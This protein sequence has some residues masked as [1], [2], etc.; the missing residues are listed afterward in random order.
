MSSRVQDKGRRKPHPAR[1][2]GT[3]PGPGSSSKSTWKRVLADDNNTGTDDDDEFD[4]KK[5]C[6]ICAEKIKY[7]ALSPCNHTTC[8]KCTFRQRALYEKKA[9]LVCRSENDTLI[10]TEQ[11]GKEYDNFNTSNLHIKNDKYGIYFTSQNA[12][13]D[14]MNMLSFRCQICKETCSDL[15]QLTEHIRSHDK[16]IC[17]ICSNNKKA[18]PFELKVYTL[19]QLQNH[20]MRG[21]EKGFPGHPLCAFCKGRRFYSD[22]ELNVHLRQDHERCHVCD[23]LQPLEPRFFKNYPDLEAHFKAEHHCCGFPEC[24]EQKFVVFPDEMEL[25]LHMA[26]VHGIK[27]ATAAFGTTGRGFQ[28]QLSTFRSPS[29]GNSS[30]SS[31][32]HRNGTPN[33]NKSADSVETKRLRFEER[34]KHYLNSS[35]T[36]FKQFQDINSNYQNGR[37]DC[38]G[39]KSSYKELFKGNSEEE[40]F[41]LLNNLSQILP[42]NSAA[43]L[44]LIAFVNKHNQ[45]KTDIESF[46]ALPGSDASGLNYGSWGSQSSGKKAKAKSS[47]DDF[48]ALP[49]SSSTP[50][51][52]PHKQTVKYKTLTVNKS[53]KS[54]GYVKVNTGNSNYVP[55]YLSPAANA[56]KP[57][58]TAKKDDPDFPELPKLATK[59]VIPRVNPIPHGNGQWDSRPG[60]SASSSAASSSMNLNELGQNLPDG[61]PITVKGKGKKKKQILFST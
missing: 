25:Q 28:S 36:G 53:G 17:T 45:K 16:Y 23:E 44:D 56:P 19:R 33:N 22:D 35:S 20:Q 57:T 26:K 10:F 37:I 60:S 46:P 48:P 7:S 11:L 32:N 43:A 21:D 50:A 9:C 34:A 6:L 54:T 27:N 59:K 29:A 47:L 40:I 38:V 12:H 24:L 4:E 13:D 52:T 18:F 41:L 2:N 5:Q 30:S 42:K 55:N 58:R 31:S 49:T 1:R 39:L 61:T 51:Y 15:K 14:T 3:N 8:H